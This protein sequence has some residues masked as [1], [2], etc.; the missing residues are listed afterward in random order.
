MSHKTGCERGRVRKTEN[1]HSCVTAKQENL[2]DG[3]VL[4][5]HAVSYEEFKSTFMCYYLIHILVLFQNRGFLGLTPS[6][7]NRIIQYAIHYKERS[8]KVEQI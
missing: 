6:A 3:H 1:R 2:H 8:V 5:N 4:T 7:L